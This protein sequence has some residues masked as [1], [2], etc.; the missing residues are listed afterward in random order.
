ML[1]KVLLVVVSLIV[2]VI[3]SAIV[4]PILFKDDLIVLVEDQANANLNADVK[5]GD[6]Y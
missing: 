6:I 1:R 2:L 3:G 4:L 5:F